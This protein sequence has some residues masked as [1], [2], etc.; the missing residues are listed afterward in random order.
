LNRA[1]ARSPR[2]RFPF[3]RV[4]RASVRGSRRRNRQRAAFGLASASRST[5]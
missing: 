1:T 4:Y 2:G 3:L 5:V